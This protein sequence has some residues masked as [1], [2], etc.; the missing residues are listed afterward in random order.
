VFIIDDLVNWQLWS[1]GPSFPQSD[2]W[3]Q[4]TSHVALSKISNWIYCYYHYVLIVIYC[5]T[6]LHSMLCCQRAA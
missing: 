2:L 6:C 5:M 3:S 4:L 1:C